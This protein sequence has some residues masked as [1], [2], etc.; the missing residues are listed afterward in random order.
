MA[1]VLKAHVIINDGAHA[2]H[3]MDVIEHRGGFWLV[4]EWLD[5][6]AKTLTTPLR[7]VS[8]GTLAHQRN[9]GAN[10]EFLVEFPVPKYVFD[11]RVP[12]GEVGKYVVVESPDILIPLAPKLH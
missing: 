12:P 11:G 4:P 6:Q 2:I 9:P 5:N 7:I 3:L 8:L 10:P 1:N